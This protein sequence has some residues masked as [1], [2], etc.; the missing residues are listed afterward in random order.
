MLKCFLG[1]HKSLQNAIVDFL[2][3]NAQWRGE[4]LRFF[5]TAGRLQRSE[6]LRVGTAVTALPF[7]AIDSY[8]TYARDELHDGRLQLIQ[9][10]I[11]QLHC[12]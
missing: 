4:P 5:A 8:S 2:F 12:Q 9:S 10:S 3:I 11:A 1:R 7:I 6:K